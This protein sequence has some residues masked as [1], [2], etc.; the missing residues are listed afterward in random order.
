MFFVNEIIRVNTW[1]QQLYI[2]QIKFKF[3]NYCEP[4][5]NVGNK[6]RKLCMQV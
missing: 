2:M 5:Q 4:S 3:S 1:T 6:V